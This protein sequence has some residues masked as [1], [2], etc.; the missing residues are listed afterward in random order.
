[1]RLGANWGTDRRPV[2]RW[3]P[4]KVRVSSTDASAAVMAN[5]T[6]AVMSIM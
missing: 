2:K 4:R 6:E 3:V 5:P 1:M